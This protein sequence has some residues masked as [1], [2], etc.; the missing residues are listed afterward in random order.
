MQVSMFV[1]LLRRLRGCGEQLCRRRRLRRLAFVCKQKSSR[2]DRRLP[3]TTIDPFVSGG[4]PT[5]SHSSADKSSTPVRCRRLATGAALTITGLLALARLTSSSTVRCI[6]LLIR[7]LVVAVVGRINLSIRLS[8]L[9]LLICY[10]CWA[11]RL[12]TDAV[13]SRCDFAWR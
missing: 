13:D 12:L 3:C 8:S 10:C 4:R 2:P 6:S 7:P 9:P 11:K 5:G 1:D